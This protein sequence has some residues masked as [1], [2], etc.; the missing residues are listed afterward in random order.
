MTEQPAFPARRSPDGY[1]AQRVLPAEPRPWVLTQIDDGARLHVALLTDDEVADWPQLYDEHVATAMPSVVG[2]LSGV[3]DAEYAAAVI[4]TRRNILGLRPRPEPAPLPLG[5]GEDDA[6]VWVPPATDA[7]VHRPDEP[8]VHDGVTFWHL[9]TR[10][11]GT[12]G[13]RP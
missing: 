11:C 3:S 12:C 1:V 6:E 13:R 8:C 5:P 4:A 2:D 10:R 7:L 9:R